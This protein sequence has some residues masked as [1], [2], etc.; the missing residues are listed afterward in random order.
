MFQGYLDTMNYYRA[1]REQGIINEDFPITSKNLQQYLFTS[2][3]AGTNIGSMGDAY[4]LYQG[5]MEENPSVQLDVAN[6]IQ[7]PRG[8]GV[9]SWNGC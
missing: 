3:K 1:L 5:A 7:G 6:R 4:T 2:G 8:L 9:W